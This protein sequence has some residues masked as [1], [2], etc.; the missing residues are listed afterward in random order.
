M[1]AGGVLGSPPQC[2]LGSSVLRSSQSASTCLSSQHVSAGRIPPIAELTSINKG[3][4][5]SRAADSQSGVRVPNQTHEGLCFGER[6]FSS[7]PTCLKLS[8]RGDLE[9]DHFAF[10]FLK[11]R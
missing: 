6:V 2:P 4:D 10:L 8:V 11:L 9:V 3:G 7:S 5:C 1:R